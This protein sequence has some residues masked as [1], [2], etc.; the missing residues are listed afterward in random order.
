M[1]CIAS[2]PSAGFIEE[3]A[4]LAA[5]KPLVTA[6]QNNNEEA[7]KALLAGGYKYLEERGEFG[8]TP[9]IMAAREGSDSSV[10]ALLAAGANK[11]AKDNVSDGYPYGDPLMDDNLSHGLRV[12]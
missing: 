10:K 3:K 12:D 2:T 4:R 5:E 8:N 6:A 7:V 9:L 11:E 1:G